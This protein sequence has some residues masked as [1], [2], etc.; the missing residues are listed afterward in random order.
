M[1]NFIMHIDLEKLESERFTL[2]PDQARAMLTKAND[3]QTGTET[4][5]NQR[6][7]ENFY[8]CLE[9]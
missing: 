6:T 8:H 2:Q 9:A 1:Y 7:R 4:S 3:T 5:G